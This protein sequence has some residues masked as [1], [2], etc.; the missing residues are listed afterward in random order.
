[1][2]KILV[3]GGS[4]YIGQHFCKKLM[5][6]DSKYEIIVIDDLSTSEIATEYCDYHYTMKISESEQVFQI[7]KNIDVIV[8]FAGS[9]SVA[10]SIKFPDIYY[11]NN[12]FESFILLELMRKYNIK[13]IIFSSSCATYGIH[14]SAISEEHNQRP[15]NPYGR[16]KLFVE[17]MLKD[18]FKAF[19]IS[20][21]SL[22]YFNAVGVSSDRK[23]GYHDNM[24]RL[25][26]CAV[27]SIMGGYEFSLYG[28]DYD[29]LDGTCIRDH[30]HVEDVIDAHLLVMKDILKEKNDINFY[31]IG[32]G[33]GTSNL[34]IIEKVQELSGKVGKVVI[35]D[36]REGDPPK[37]IADIKKF[38]NKYPQ[39]QPQHD[40][41][42][43]ISSALDWYHLYTIKKK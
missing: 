35:K 39:W 19:D 31:N 12:T 28:G 15:V 38:R 18:Y 3:T 5:E 1:M 40:L 11:K 4:G 25:I 13:K 6:E 37:L 24:N 16:S 14:D 42:S 26:P 9:A 2:I 8:H 41:S 7:H 32:T 17:Q 29:T 21:T 30:I 27:E 36:R 20:S 43:I 23:I 22:R 10:E 33:I 34:E